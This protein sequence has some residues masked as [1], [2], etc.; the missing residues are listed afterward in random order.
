MCTTASQVLCRRSRGPRSKAQE[1][2]YPVLIARRL[3]EW[4]GILVFGTFSIQCAARHKDAGLNTGDRRG[5]RQV[6]FVEKLGN[7]PSVP[8][9]RPYISSAFYAKGWARCCRQNSA[10]PHTPNAT[11]F[12]GS[13]PSQTARRTVHPAVLVT[14]AE[15]KNLGHAP[16]FGDVSKINLWTLKSTYRLL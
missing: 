6:P 2:R 15:I 10:A 3:R 11:R 12:R 5:V 8:I 4:A 7:V 14:P 9:F 1:T 13:R 16:R